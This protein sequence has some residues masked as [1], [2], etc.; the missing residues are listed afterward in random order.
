[1]EVV[2]R[3]YRPSG[4]EEYGIKGYDVDQNGR[5]LYPY[6]SREDAQAYI[7]YLQDKQDNAGEQILTQ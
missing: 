7:D 4:I 6:G 1:M 3:K 5:Q 2:T